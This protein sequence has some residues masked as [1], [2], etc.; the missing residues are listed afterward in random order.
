MQIRPATPDD[1]PSVLPMVVKICELHTA[2]DPAKYA[3]RGDP[4]QRYRD[5]M[6]T[7]ARDPRSVFLVA[8][9]AAA[10]EAT[11][12]EATAAG[13]ASNLVGFLVAGVQD[14]VPIYR[15]TE[16]GFIYDLWVEERYRNEGIA[17]QMVT[18]AIERFRAIG[19]MQVR[20]DTAQANEPAQ[21]LFKSCGFRPSIIEWLIEI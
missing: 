8:D 2:L 20:L 17:R 1:V 16:F 19:V 14:E 13:G 15:I 12:A 10:A 11:A 21:S 18:L 3:I 5:W 7:R 6:I 4:A 9:A